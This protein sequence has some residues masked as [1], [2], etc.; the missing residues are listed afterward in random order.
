MS[1]VTAAWRSP[2]ALSVHRVSA[3]FSIAHIR[4]RSQGFRDELHGV[5]VVAMPSTA[6]RAD[7]AGPDLVAVHDAHPHRAFVA[8]K[9]IDQVAGHTYSRAVV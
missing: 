6:S 3:A 7:G 1:R 4:E 5:T 8:A 2:A 9:L